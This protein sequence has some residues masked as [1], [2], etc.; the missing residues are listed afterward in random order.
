MSGDQHPGTERE[1]LTACLDRQRHAL[2]RKVEGLT[3]ADAR[4]A[5]TASSLSLLGLL[6]HAA[7]W[8]ERWWQGVVAGRP[9][10]D[11]WPDQ[12]PEVPDADF[13]VGDDDTVALAVAR[14]REAAEVARSIVATTELD[15]PCARLDVFDG[16]VRWVLLHL[17]EETARHAGHADILRESL[18]GSRGT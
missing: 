6:K 4:R 1:A 9:L 16:N 5:P 12:Q 8:E 14:Y 15:A 7:T 18:D 2:L 11:G 13:L 10:A 3:E 17:V